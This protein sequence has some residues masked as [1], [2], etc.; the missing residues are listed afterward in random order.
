MPQLSAREA[1][2]QTPLWA[3]LCVIVGGIICLIA[4]VALMARMWIIPIWFPSGMTIFFVAV[5]AGAIFGLGLM[6]WYDIYD[7]D[8]WEE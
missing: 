4:V 1:W 5:G 6:R 2:R 3:R 7:P 8:D